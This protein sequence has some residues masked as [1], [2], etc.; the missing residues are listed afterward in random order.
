MTLHYHQTTITP[1]ELGYIH[2]LVSNVLMT[3]G[4]KDITTLSEWEHQL[5]KE[6]DLVRQWTGHVKHELFDQ[7]EQLPEGDHL[8][9]SYRDE[10]WTWDDQDI[11]QVRRNDNPQDHK[12]I[13]ESLLMD[14]TP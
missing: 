12:V 3:I 5:L 1:R 13:E 11:S 8:K 4:T 14:G 9:E 2:N 6:T 10:V 7:W